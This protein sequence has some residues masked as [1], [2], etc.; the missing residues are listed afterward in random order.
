MFDASFLSPLHGTLENLSAHQGISKPGLYLIGTPIG[1]LADISLRALAALVSVDVLYCEDTRVTRKLLEA[2]GIQRPLRVY[3]THNAQKTK[4]EMKALIQEGK[5][6][7][8]VSD[9]GMPLISDPGEGVVSLCL[10][11]ASTV[12]P[13]PS[14]GIAALVGAGLPTQSFHFFGFLPQQK[15]ERDALLQGAAGHP[16]S[17]IFY[18]APH[19][20]LKTLRALGAVLGN[21]QAV[22]ARE[23]TKKFEE[24]RRGTLEDLAAFYDQ[25]PK[26]EVV[27]VVEGAPQ[28]T[29][30]QA[31]VM[32][33]LKK[34]RPYLRLK[35]ASQ[36]VSDLTG[37]SKKEIYDQGLRLL[38]E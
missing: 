22:V 4:H 20:L 11:Q 21:R 2:Y 19:R 14:A 1:N 25:A 37:V 13:G 35:E 12:I 3:H 15:K 17:L 33:L 31:E 18:E 6:V 24:M 7:G 38:D 8:L 5:S 23:L 29:T 27:V 10:E 36:L 30:D 34:V 16:G 32:A 9:A 26:G 28:K